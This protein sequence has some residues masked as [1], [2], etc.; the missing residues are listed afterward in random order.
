[1]PS[2]SPSR[3]D[4]KE[5]VIFDGNCGFCTA[6]SSELETLDKEDALKFVPF[7]DPSVQRGLNLPKS[8]QLDYMFFVDQ[9]G[10]IYKGAKAV[11]EAM[12]RLPGFWGAVGQVFSHRVFMPI[13]ELIYGF[14]ARKRFLI[15]RLLRLK[16]YFEQDRTLQ[17]D[18]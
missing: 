6:A 9:H 8:N 18:P 15:S 10:Q 3:H 14:I 1:M 11:F 13:S 7:Q 4:R 2:S 12:K 17:R 5:L 16:P